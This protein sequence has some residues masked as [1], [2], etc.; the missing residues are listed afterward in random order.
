MPPLVAPE[1]AA[2]PP[3]LP[4]IYLHV[5]FCK[6]LCPYCDFVKVRERGPAP[7]SFIE[8]LVRE[9]E[10]F[11]AG[12]K[13]FGSVFYGGG[14][15]SRLSPAQLQRVNQSLRDCLNLAPGAEWSLEANPDDITPEL[16][17][18]FL[19]AGIN[20]VSLGVQSFDSRVLKFLGRRHD[21]A[22]ARR[23]CG[24]VAA[25]FDNWSLDLMFGAPPIEAWPDT[26]AEAVAL[27]PP[28]LSA[29]GLTYEA[30]TPFERRAK[31]ATPDDVMLS[32]YQ[33]LE[34]A[35]AGYDHYEISN[36][37]KP[38]RRARHNL[39]YWHNLPYAGFGTGA[40][41]YWNG[42]RA[43]NHVSLERYL[44]EPGAKE[45]STPITPR[46]ERVE[47]VIQHMRLRDGLPLERYHTRFGSGVMEDFGGPLQQLEARGLV[48]VDAERLRPTREGFYLN[49]EIG[50]ALVG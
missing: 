11:D 45:E 29:Y 43:R 37:A 50:L 21:A 3:P 36:F 7:D 5:P 24:E 15:P 17:D 16:L 33:S 27:D 1:D 35:L 31:D 22:A 46:E 47:T 6:T 30:G 12:G 18:G 41:A 13:R 19:E 20:R 42:I 8:A 44:A 23:A 49:N 2:A 34:A 39:V 4:G 32:L 14:T 28:H 38:G 10:A 9:I 25:R 26:L 48:S 40:Y